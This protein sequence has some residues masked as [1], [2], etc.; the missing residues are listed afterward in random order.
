MR[1]DRNTN[2][3]GKGKYA[4]INLRRAAPF[5][6]NMDVRAA[7]KVLDWHGLI[8][9]G[10]VG[11]KDEFFVIKLCDEFSQNALLQYSLTAN[12]E[13]LR[14]YAQD[15]LEMAKRAGADSPFCKKP[16]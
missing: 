6:D 11:S 4:L 1:L 12:V 13:G 10:D 16:D 7:F 3:K 5:G 2:Q 15:V 8:D 14:E 9:W